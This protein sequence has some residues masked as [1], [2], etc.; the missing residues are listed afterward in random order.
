MKRPPVCD[1]TKFYSRLWRRL[2]SIIIGLSLNLY[3]SKDNFHHIRRLKPWAYSYKFSCLPALGSHDHLQTA[4]RASVVTLQDYLTTMS[5]TLR[6]TI[7]SCQLLNESHR[8][9]HTVYGHFTL[10]TVDIVLFPNM[11]PRFPVHDATSFITVTPWRLKASAF[12]LFVQLLRLTSRKKIQ[13]PHHWPFV[14][15]S[16]SDRWIHFKGPVTQKVCPCREIIMLKNIF[17]PAL[18]LHC[19]TVK[20]LK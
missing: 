7:T 12:R 9:I 6:I 15:G 4:L 5:P 17:N 3:F 14:R 19:Y 1:H 20:S 10:G 11:W 8:H 13:V 18:F 2:S 16:S